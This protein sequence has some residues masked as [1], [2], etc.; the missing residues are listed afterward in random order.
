MEARSVEPEPSE[1]SSINPSLEAHLG[2]DSFFKLEATEEDDYDEKEVQF[3]LELAKF[4]PKNVSRESAI[5]SYISEVSQMKL[6]TGLQE[7]ELGRGIQVGNKKSFDKLVSSNLRLVISIAKRYT[8]QGMDLED[9]IQEGNLGLLI[10]AVRFDPNRGNKFSTY[11]TWWIRQSVTRAI[12]NKSRT[13]RVP[14]HIHEAF[15]RLKQA[16]IPFLQKF[17]RYPTIAELTDSTNIRASEILHVLGSTRS[18]L[19]LDDFV[20]SEEDETIASF[21][22]D[23]DHPKPEELAEKHLLTEQ[24]KNLL[25]KLTAEEQKVMRRLY[26]LEGIPEM[27]A[28]QV[29]NDLRMPIE[30]VRITEARALRKLKRLTLKMRMKDFLE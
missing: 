29:A 10:A 7:V 27:N 12:A 25:C 26:G 20:G 14:V 1:Y 30:S 2:D 8:H 4:S 3:K 17:G 16:S 5:Y 28:R 22:E 11:A 23:K 18:S 15:R 19:S 21:V 9:L 13:V 6:L 24:I